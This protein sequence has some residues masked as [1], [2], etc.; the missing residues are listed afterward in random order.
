MHDLNLG[1]EH[2]CDIKTDSRYD[3]G[4]AEASEFSWCTSCM[5]VGE[6]EAGG[7]GSCCASVQKIVTVL[8]AS[9]C[10]LNE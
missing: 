3:V 8:G 7:D 4:Y 9:S 2:A 5:V 10:L 6:I 1:R